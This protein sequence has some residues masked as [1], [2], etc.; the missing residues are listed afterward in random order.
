MSESVPKEWR[1]ASGLMVARAIEWIKKAARGDPKPKKRGMAM[2]IEARESKELMA[3]DTWRAWREAPEELMLWALK[4]LGE[5]ERGWLME[6]SKKVDPWASP[7]TM[8]ATTQEIARGMMS[9][10]L[11]LD[12]PSK[13]EDAEGISPG[14]ALAMMGNEAQLC[15]WMGAG[16]EAPKAWSQEQAKARGAIWE[17]RS[18]LRDALPGEKRSALHWLAIAPRAARALDSE[19]KLKKL[20]EWLASGEGAGLGLK[21]SQGLD[22]LRMAIMAGNA[23]L[24]CALLDLGADPW[25]LDAKGKSAIDMWERAQKG[26]VLR[27]EPKEAMRLQ[28]ALERKQLERAGLSPE[29]ARSPSKRM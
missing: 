25:A 1:E 16:S 4:E 8:W 7:Q 17:S 5:E 18:G 20:C 22:A 11:R 3:P 15:A 14:M 13:K 2:L 10:G 26:D 19:E 27:K 6:W 23:R 12:E 24:A 21:N 28:A 29:S 9:A